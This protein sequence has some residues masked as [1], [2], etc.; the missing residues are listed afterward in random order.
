MGNFIFVQ[1]HVGDIV[2]SPCS[3]YMYFSVQDRETALMIASWNGH[4]GCVNLLLEKGTAKFD[5]QD[6]VSSQS[7]FI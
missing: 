1:V 7:F 3:V 5:L 2:I 6:E 4:V